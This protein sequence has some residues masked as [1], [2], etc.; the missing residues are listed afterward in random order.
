[1]LGDF[2]EAEEIGEMHDSR[3]IRVG[4]LD[5]TTTDKLRGP[6]HALHSA[7]ASDACKL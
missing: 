2:H 3:Q 5:T 4:K 7:A 6:T 1:M